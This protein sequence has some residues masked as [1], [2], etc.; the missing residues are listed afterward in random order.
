MDVMA[1]ERLMQALRDSLADIK[2]GRV[3]PLDEVAERFELN[4]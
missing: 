2:A 3:L 4:R 1:D